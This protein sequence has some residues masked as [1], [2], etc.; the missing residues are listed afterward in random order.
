MP[1]VLRALL[2]GIDDYPEPVP[3]LAGS[4]NDIDAMARI[5]EARIPAGGLELV[6]LH[7]REAT[8]AAVTAAI[9]EHLGAV[10]PGDSALFCF[11]GH[12]SQ[13]HAPPELWPGEPDRRNETLVLADSRS[14][15]GWDL[16]DK[17]LAGLLSVVAS[18]CEHVLVILDCCHAGSGTRDADLS[19]RVRLAPEDERLRPWDTFLPETV[20]RAGTGVR[21]PWGRALD[22]VLLAAC[23][24]TETAKEVRVDGHVRGALSAG[25]DRALRE[26]G[27]RPTYRDIHRLAAVDVLSRVERQH[28]QLEAAH[29]IDLDRVFLGGVL[30]AR[31]RQLTLSHLPAGWTID[32]GAVHGVPEPIDEDTTELA[33]YP[34]DGATDS[35][36]VATGAV[37]SVL[38]DRS[39]VTLTPELDRSILYRAV[40]TSIPLSPLDVAVSG[41]AQR[42]D[43]LVAAAASADSTLIRLVADTP[44]ADLVVHAREDGF[45]ITRPGVSRPVVPVVAGPDHTARTVSALERVARWMRLSALTNPT[46]GLAPG[47]VSMTAQTPTGVGGDGP[48][49]ISYAAG[50]APAFTV[51]VV[52]T[53]D[54]PLWCALVDLTETYGIYTDAFA[55][56]SVMLGPGESVSVALS[57]QVSDELWEAGTTTVTD[58][59]KLVT[60][61]LEFDPRSLEQ[62]DLDVRATSAP[63]VRGVAGTTRSTLDRLLTRVATLTRAADGAPSA[64]ADWRTDDLYVVTHRPRP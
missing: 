30:P 14:P 37:T 36:P 5:L 29:A 47:S 10:R 51:T 15:G 49:E 13:Q 53:T 19:L 40:I 23:R 41:S 25:L 63:V 8:R 26:A 33:V 39:L 43:E 58:H 52:N 46:T 16:A 61:T 3:P 56:G 64:V 27:G 11:S 55:A 59:L 1:D 18:R 48:L 34:L 4:R 20:G 42:R 54:M 22:H 62:P 2:V 17:E 24:S 6:V 60:S 35:S 32:V 50:S 28:P 21:S 57:G 44:D 31:P 9:R 38:T 7:D 45:E 12:G